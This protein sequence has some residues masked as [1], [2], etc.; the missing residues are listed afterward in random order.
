MAEVV[1]TLGRREG[2]ERWPHRRPQARHGAGGAGSEQRFEFG[3]DLLDRIEVGAV[4]GQVQ[5][6]SASGFDRL[7]DPG[8]FMARQ[9]VHDDPVAW[10]ERRDQN[11]FDIG[12]EAQAID[13]AVE[14][15][16]GGQLVGA[17]GG[18]DGGRLPVAGGDFRDEAGAAPPA[19][20]APG[21]LRLERG[22]VQE[23][24]P[25]AVE[26]R[27]LG[28][29]ALPGYYDIRPLLF[30]GVQDFFLRSAPGGARPARPW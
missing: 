4:R 9:I 11:L 22:L 29:P 28:A 26:L 20:I 27:R 5:E 10:A 2:G 13:R 23:D 12:H 19:A 8:H 1:G 30:G 18:N 15:G 14:D 21:H 3:K 16:R 17:E 24:E 6:G 25:V 7:A